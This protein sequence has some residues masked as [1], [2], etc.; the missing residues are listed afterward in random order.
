[1]AEEL[2][3]EDECRE[4]EALADANLRLL[5]ESSLKQDVE[6]IAQRQLQHLVAEAEEVEAPSVDKE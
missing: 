5:R 2:A 4:R 3:K 6:V 1:M